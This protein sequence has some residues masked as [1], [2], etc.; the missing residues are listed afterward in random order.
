M[1]QRDHLIDLPQEL[2]RDFIR[3]YIFEH[4]EQMKDVSQFPWGTLLVTGQMD[5]SLIRQFWEYVED[6]IRNYK[7]VNNVLTLSNDFKREFKMIE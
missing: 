3:Q 1:N 6:N 5:E 7:A 4:L 2:R